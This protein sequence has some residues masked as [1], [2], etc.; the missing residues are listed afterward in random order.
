M[1]KILSGIFFLL[2]AFQAAGQEKLT[3]DRPGESKSPELVKGNHFQVEA[4]FRK[5]KPDDHLH[6]YHHPSAVLRYG[7]FN[8][9]ELRMEIT[10]QTIR[11]RLNKAT[12]NGLKPLEFG[13]KAKVLPEYNG[14]PSIAMLGTIGI[15]STSSN[16]YFN[17]RI[18]VEFRTLLGNTLSRNLKLQYNG[19]I[20]WEGDDRTARWMYSVSPIFEIS[21]RFSVFIEEY[22]FLRKAGS[23]QHYINGGV[24]F[25]PKN[26]LMFDVSGGLGLSDQS[27]DYFLAAGITFRLPVR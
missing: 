4:G 7:L 26:N 10:S 2:I 19:G 6:L 13:V 17:R 12:L 27:S 25:Y 21:N 14:F 9:I 1:G 11:D 3:A 18:P 24:E 16:D 15:P 23:P 20:K 5:E 22:A 8:A